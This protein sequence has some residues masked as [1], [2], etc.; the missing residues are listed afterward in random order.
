MAARD[1]HRQRELRVAA[2]LVGLSGLATAFGAAAAEPLQLQWVDDATGRPV[3]VEVVGVAPPQVAAWRRLPPDDPSWPAV[4]AVYVDEAAA[5]VPPILGRYTIE[6]DRLRFTPHFA[7]RPAV[8]YRV[9]FRVPGGEAA[10]LVMRRQVAPPPPSPATRVVAIYPS[11]EVLPE[12]HLRFYIH[13]SAPMSAGQAYTHIQLL[14]EDGQVVP[15][16]FLEIGEELWDA[17]FTRLTL[18]FDPG[19]VKQGLK[20]REEFGPV[21]VAGR[22]YILRIDR[23]WQDA[24]GQ[25]LATDFEKRFAAGPAVE[26]AVDYRKWRIDPPPA[27]SRQ[28]LVVRL[29]R[30]LDRALLLRMITVEGPQGQAVEGEVS[31]ADQERTWL[32]EPA[33]AWEAGPYALV[34]DTALEDSAGNNLQRPFEV[35]VFRQVDARPGPEL[36]RVPWMVGPAAA[37]R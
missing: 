14:T 13:F 32:F 11:A 31:L 19:R 28:R 15:R 4:L 25:P 21:L 1:G 22:R 33:V 30:P 16:A 18:L 3:A 5:E 17:Q 37:S 10:P 8:T 20:P 12:N 6:G 24:A 26:T 27:G 2:V 23:R 35:D 9:E 36:V 34:V 7:F 29:D